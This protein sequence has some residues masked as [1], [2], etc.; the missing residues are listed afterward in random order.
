MTL[1]T[2]LALAAIAFGGACIAVQ[3]PINARLAAHVGD[4][5]AASAISFAVGLV[6]LVAIT[7]LVGG[8]P[9]LEEASGAPWWA[10]VGGFL[11]AV[12]V[13]AAIWSVGTLGVVTMVAGLIFGQLAA[14]LILDAS[15]AFGIAVREI[16]WTRLAAVGFVAVGL[17]L[18]R[19]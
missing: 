18:S 5:V 6:V 15:G 10:W 1:Q 11:G 14:A 12:Y 8:V 17:V 19:I 2:L 4:P 13:W 3:A 16:S 7:V 9:T